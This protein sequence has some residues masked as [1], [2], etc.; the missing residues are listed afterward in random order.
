MQL[1]T[2]IRRRDITHNICNCNYRLSVAKCPVGRFHMPIGGVSDALTQR[3][4]H[5][6]AGRIARIDKITYWIV[7]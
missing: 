5:L 1:T 2:S 4:S 6:A 3:H 7:T